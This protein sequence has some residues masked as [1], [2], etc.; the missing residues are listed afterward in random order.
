[1]VARTEGDTWDIT[2]GVAATAIGAAARAAET[3]SKNPLLRDP[4]ARLF[5]DAAGQGVWSMWSGGAAARG[6]AR[7]LW[8]YI[9]GFS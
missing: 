3:E 1:M 5:T 7:D 4:F 9:D 8:Y 2:E 6:D